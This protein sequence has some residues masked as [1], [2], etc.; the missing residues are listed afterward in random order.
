MITR[1]AC[2]TERPDVA[3]SSKVARLRSRRSPASAAA[4]VST[5]S[6]AAS[7]SL[8]RLPTA[9]GPSSGLDLLLLGLLVRVLLPFL[10]LLLVHMLARFAGGSDPQDRADG[11]AED[12]ASSLL[13]FLIALRHVTLLLRVH[14]VFGLG[15]RP[16]GSGLRRGAGLARAA[17]HHPLVAFLGVLRL[18]SDCL[19][20]LLGLGSLGRYR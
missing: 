5:G 9:S 17:R 11:A 3:G 4:G 6:S 10:L 15:L 16:G 18:F 12:S 7:S 20:G 13:L 2:V 14:V 1:V 8:L 19:R